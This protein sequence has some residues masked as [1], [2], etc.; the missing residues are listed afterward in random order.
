MTRSGPTVGRDV[1]LLSALSAAL[2]V[3]FVAVPPR[4]AARVSGVEIADSPTLRSTFQQ[5]FIAYWTSGDRD[6]PPRL[7]RVVDYWAGF[8]LAKAVLA[9]LLLVA[10]TALGVQLWTAFVRADAL[11][12]A[13]RAATAAA[14]VLVVPLAVLSLLVVMANIQGAAAPFASLLP[15]L[16]E[17]GPG[18]ELGAVLGRV[19][20]SLAVVPPTTQSPPAL[21]TMIGDFSRYHAVMVVIAAMVAIVLVVLTMSCWRSLR[22]TPPADR[23]RRHVVGSFGLVFAMLSLAAGV[24]AVANHSTTADPA[25]AL[26]VML[27]GGW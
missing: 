1:T 14:G 23:R 15:F 11:G 12:P 22:T 20:Q 19:E 8:H 2:M 3:A 21:A 16:V 17:G 24:V 6:F 25:P 5:A 27:T 9:A 26:R 13:G 18:G 10:L 4:W 7:A